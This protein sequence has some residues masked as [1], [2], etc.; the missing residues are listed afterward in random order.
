MSKPHL[1]FM[2][3]GGIIMSGLARWCHADGYRV[4]GCDTVLNA[5]TERLQSQGIPVLQGHSPDH[6]TEADVLVSTVAIAAEHPELEA[7]RR[8]ERRVLKRIELLAELFRQRRGVA[9]TGTHGKS[10]TTGMTAS[11]FLAA[12]RDPSVLV[13]AQLPSIGGNVHYGRSDELIAEVDESDP[14]FA[15]I[16][17]SLAVVTNLGDDHIAGDYRERRTYH[18]SF[19]DLE[20]A[21]DAFADRAER[22]LYCADWPGLD[23]LLAGRAGGYRY[24]FAGTADYRA[25]ITSL[26]ANGSTFDLV[27]PSGERY[28]VRLAVPGRHNV[29]NATAA[30]AA[31]HLMGLDLSKTAPSLAAFGGVGRRWQRRGSVSQALFIDDYAVHPTEVRVVLQ[32]AKDT[33]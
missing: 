18:A 25:V 11:L 10:T 20:A 5:E 17:S 8:L 22:L 14:G 4:S 33:G 2:G 16:A 13:G 29:Q 30:L 27:I 19:A 24:G 12:G 15:G 21:M 31:T 23:R 3:I 9:I 26:S 28:P 7:A 32:L 6:V 1:H